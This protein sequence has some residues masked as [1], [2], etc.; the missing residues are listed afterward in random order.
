MDSLLT[1]ALPSALEDEF[2][3]LL[4]EQADLVSGFTVL[5]GFGLGANVALNT[6]M[7]RVEGRARR[8][9]VQVLLRADDVEP[10]VARI[11]A[12]MKSPHVFYWAVPLQ[13][14]GRLG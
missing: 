12:A 5:H 8:V 13:A 9:L 3:D 10:L 7:E 11:R 14:C 6:V 1:I 4:R 2:L